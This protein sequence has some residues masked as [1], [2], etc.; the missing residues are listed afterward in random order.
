MRRVAPHIL[1]CPNLSTLLLQQNYNLGGIPGSFFSCM[2]NLTYLDLSCTYLKEIPKEICCLV[3]VRYLNLSYT[4]ISSLPEE[5]VQLINLKYLLLQDTHQ[6]TREVKGIIGRLLKLEYLDL[7]PFGSVDTYELLS[8][9]LLL[10]A[11]GTNITSGHALQRLSSVPIVHLNIEDMGDSTTTLSSSTKLSLRELRFIDCHDNIRELDVGVRLPRLDSLHLHQLNLTEIVWRSVLPASECFQMLREINISRCHGLKD[12]TWVLHLP[13]L[14]ELYVYDCHEMEQLVVTG[15]GE[16]G[17]KPT[18]PRLRR[19]GLR[20]LRK[21]AMICDNHVDFPSMRE[22]HV[23]KCNVLKKLPF[24]RQLLNDNNCC[25]L[26]AIQG[27]R[28]WWESIEWED[29]AQSS[30]L[31]PFFDA[32]CG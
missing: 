21:L 13:C 26:K 22:L 25:R 18:F 9:P 10:K 4:E 8:S 28:E 1:P 5:L 6:L 12:I 24:H 32:M 23:Y 20:G 14:Q 7:Y 19:L 31:Q 11:L 27:G 17:K 29:S 3:Q 2:P 15:G 30:L 16:V